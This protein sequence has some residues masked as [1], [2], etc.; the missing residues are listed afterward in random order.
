MGRRGGGGAWD[1][2][3]G[4]EAQRARGRLCLG[5]EV[6]GHLLAWLLGHGT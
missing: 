1:E 5:E 4:I 3:I 6:G 2:G